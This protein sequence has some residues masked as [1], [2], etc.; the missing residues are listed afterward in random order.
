[1]AE[2]LTELF[3]C[4]CRKEVFPPE[5]KDA[6]II[7]LCSWMLFW[8]VIVVFQLGTRFD[9][10]MVN[11]KR[12]QAKPKEQTDLLDVLLYTD[13]M[14]RNAQRQKCKGPWIKS[15]SRVITIISQLAQ[16]Y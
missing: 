6:F 14:V 9:G 7:L 3:H 1:M 10:N 16:K 2:R 15:H 5:F 8:T 12:L 4:M 11:L 13:D